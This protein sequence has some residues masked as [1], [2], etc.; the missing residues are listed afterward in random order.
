MTLA[1]LIERHHAATAEPPDRAVLTPRG[2]AVTQVVCLERSLRELSRADRAYIVRRLRD[3][4]A[5]RRRYRT[6]HAEAPGGDCV[7]RAPRAAP[8]LR[9][10]RRREDS[11]P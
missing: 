11:P 6:E 8:R 1:E 5:G 4:L 10:A 9:S 2:Q 3:L 7:R